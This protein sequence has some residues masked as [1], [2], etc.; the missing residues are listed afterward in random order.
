M[1]IHESQAYRKMDVARERISRILELREILL[2]FRTGTKT[3]N[4]AAAGWVLPEGCV[5]ETD[6]SWLTEFS[7]TVLS[8]TLSRSLD[9]FSWKYHP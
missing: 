3:N 9:C 7:D 5:H 4:L 2:S 8:F 1:S 6:P